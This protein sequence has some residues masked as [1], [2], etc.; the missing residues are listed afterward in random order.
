ME[1]TYMQTLTES[2]SFRQKTKQKQARISRTSTNKINVSSKHIEKN[3]E[4][5]KVHWNGIHKSWTVYLAENN[6]HS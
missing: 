5:K 4:E 3:L 2:R 1:K 6:L